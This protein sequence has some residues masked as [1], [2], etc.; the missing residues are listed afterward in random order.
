MED[1]ASRLR[2][3]VRDGQ[4][5][6]P[7]PQ[8]R[9]IVVTSGKGGVGK[10]NVA[11][12]L[13]LAMGQLGQRVILFDADMGMANVDVVLNMSPPHTLT[14]VLA[15]RRSLREVLAPIEPGVHLVP[16]GS[17]VAQLAALES[18]RL[19]ATVQRLSELE[20]L[21]DVMIVDTGAGISPNVLGFVLAAP[22]VIVVTT[23]EPT[24]IV[25][26]YGIIKAIDQ[27]NQH[28]R[29]WLLVN[30][31]ASENEARSVY[32]RLVAIIA[33][34]LGVKVRLLGW[35][36]R[37]PQVGR[38]V[39]QQKPFVRA[40]PGGVPARRIVAVAEK[41]LGFTGVGSGAERQ[42]FFARWGQWFA[43]KA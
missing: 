11:V 14:D 24:S 18:A 19:E 36:E 7:R 27:R 40:F 5:A 33:R 4:S 22:E 43:P 38:A 28:A 6:D 29:V 25:D 35:I 15:G 23:P 16:G 34:F 17:G 20:R 42:G 8:A 37:D 3:L 9:I 2:E 26:A 39:L 1:Q 13:A 10:T 12:N 32:D 31:C 21:S 41:L 30:M